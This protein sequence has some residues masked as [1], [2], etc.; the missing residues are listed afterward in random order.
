MPVTSIYPFISANQG[1]LPLGPRVPGVPRVRRVP[2]LRGDQQ[3]HRQLRGHEEGGEEQW[4]R[5]V[6]VRVPAV[7]GEERFRVRNARDIPWVITC[8]STVWIKAWIR[9]RII[10]EKQFLI[11]SL[12][13]TQHYY[14]ASM[15]CMGFGLLVEYFKI[16]RIFNYCFCFLEFW[17][18]VS[19]LIDIRFR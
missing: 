16:F 17:K 10:T 4:R 14:V 2:L 19:I 8:V 6:C 13:M 3:Q 1:V 18:F 11:P 5:E 9:R 7:Q 12:T 15:S